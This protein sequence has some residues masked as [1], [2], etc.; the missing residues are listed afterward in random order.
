MA[1]DDVADE[2]RLTIAVGAR[3]VELAAAIY[4]AVAVVIGFAL[5]YP[6]VRH[7]ANPSFCFT[8]SML[9]SQKPLPATYHMSSCG[10]TGKL[11]N[12]MKMQ[13]ERSVCAVTMGDCTSHPS[14][15]RFADSVAVQAGER[16][17][18]WHASP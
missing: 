11:G 17:G 3:Q 5:K 18:S 10:Q 7:S 8:G 13:L 15:A 16:L 14:G 6:L 1:F 4:G 9:V 12:N 2:S